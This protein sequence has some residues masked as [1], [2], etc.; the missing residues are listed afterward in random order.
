MRIPNDD[1]AGAVLQ[2]GACCDKL[3][4][5]GVTGSRGSAAINAKRPFEAKHSPFQN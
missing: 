4:P 2:E 1:P 3:R 5:P